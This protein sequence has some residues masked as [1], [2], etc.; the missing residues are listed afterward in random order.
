M[1]VERTARMVL[2]GFGSVWVNV[3]GGRIS[4]V[5][6]VSRALGDGCM[7]VSGTNSTNMMAAAWV[8]NDKMAD[9]PMRARP[10]GSLQSV[11]R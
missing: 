2:L 5:T 10:P 11:S 4:G 7:N 3:N 9:R 6:T 1:S 8:S